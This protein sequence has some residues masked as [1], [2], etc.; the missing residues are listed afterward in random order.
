MTVRLKF[1]TI[2][3]LPPD[4]L[5]ALHDIPRLK[6]MGF[7][8]RFAPMD[9]EFTVY[10]VDFVGGNVLYRLGNPPREEFTIQC[11]A[12]L[13][14]IVDGSVSRHWQGRV[15]TGG[16]LVFWP[17]SW[18]AEFYHDRLSDG[19]PTISAD[20]AKIRELMKA[21]ATAAAR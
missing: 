2:D 12:A 20:F 21:E 6:A 17:P 8:G 19:D 7:D 15:L 5:G 11:L 13:F 14:E 10:G 16:K 3:E 1:G 9:T 18:F 4:L